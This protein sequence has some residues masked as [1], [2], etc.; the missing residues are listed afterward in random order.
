MD[1]SVISALSTFGVGG[2]IA[3]MFFWWLITKHVP[4][5]LEENRKDREMHAHD[6]QQLYETSNANR[7]AII[8]K[9][10]AVQD[11]T[12]AIRKKLEA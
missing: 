4:A 3:I 11:D 9:V 5:L 2:A 7:D 1:A 10:D 6:M 12:K 8:N